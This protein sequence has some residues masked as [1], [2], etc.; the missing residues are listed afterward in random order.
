MKLKKEERIGYIS[1]IFTMAGAIIVSFLGDYL[2]VWILYAIASITGIIHNKK[3]KNRSMLYTFIFY[4]I[5]NVIA[6]VRLLT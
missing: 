1:L 3:T 2:I 4:L 6:M 5:M